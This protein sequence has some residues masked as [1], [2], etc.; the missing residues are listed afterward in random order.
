MAKKTKKQ[1]VDIPREALRASL[2]IFDNAIV[3]TVYDTHDVKKRAA[4]TVEQVIE[5]LGKSTA[6]K[7]QWIN[8]DRN[9]IS[10]CVSNS[11]VKKCLLIRAA[12]RT[13]IEYKVGKRARRLKVNVPNLLVEMGAN[14][15]GWKSIE[16]IYAFAG[17][18]SRL[19]E[20][21]ILYVPPLPNIPESCHVCMGSVKVSA[22]GKLPAGRAFEEAFFG[23]YFTD[24]HINE[25][26]INTGKYR[27]I[28]HALEKTRG[29]VSFSLLKKV[30]TYGKI[31][32]R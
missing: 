21:T 20:R 24:H 16:R 8:V 25:P 30:G 11:G 14:K 9:V 15:K 31:S 13:L 18:A 29:N 4:I 26:L 17:R 10:L 1:P 27:N 12:A 3:A 5:L 32:K 22:W 23:T 19:N 2:D 7:S 28:I 6:V